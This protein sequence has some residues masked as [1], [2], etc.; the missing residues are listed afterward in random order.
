MKFVVVPLAVDGHACRRE[1]LTA[2][3]LHAARAGDHHAPGVAQRGGLR[4][5]RG[6]RTERGAARHHRRATAPPTAWT[7]TTRSPRTRRSARPRSGRCTTSPPTPTRSTSTRCSSRSSTAS[8]FDGPPRGRRSVGDRLQ[9]HGHRLSRRDHP[10]QGAVRPGRALRVALPHRRA[11]GQRDDAAVHRQLIAPLNALTVPVP[12]NTT[13][14]T[15]DRTLDAPTSEADFALPATNPP[16][17]QRPVR[18]R[19][20]RDMRPGCRPHTRDRPHRT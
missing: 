8:R 17:T 5:P 13:A 2:P 10:G 1:Q 12:R 18:H 9:G 15:L 16:T 7:G 4:G 20:R 3:P 6:R 19:H 14:L 11:R